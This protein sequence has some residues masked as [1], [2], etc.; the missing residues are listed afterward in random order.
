MRVRKREKERDRGE[1]ERERE[2]AREKE[3][4]RESMW[5]AML[6]VLQPRQ[7]ASIS[8]EGC[9]FLECFPLFPLFEPH[10]ASLRC[11]GLHLFESWLLL[12]PR[13]MQGM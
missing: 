13:M 1:R 5:T 12:Y 10:A 2:G 3:R 8:V 7:M 11:I 4:E 6:N 9:V